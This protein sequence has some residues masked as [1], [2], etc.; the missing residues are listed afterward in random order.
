[1]FLKLDRGLKLTKPNKQ[2]NEGLKKLG[3]ARVSLF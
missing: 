1:M 3:L 2:I